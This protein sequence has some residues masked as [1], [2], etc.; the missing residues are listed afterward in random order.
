MKKII[1]LL[2]ICLL[3]LLV[4]GKSLTISPNLIDKTY[5]IGD[6]QLSPITVTISNND[7]TSFNTSLSVVD[8]SDF[9]YLS[10]QGL[11]FNGT[12]S[13][14]FIVYFNV[15]SSATVGLKTE[16][17]IYSDGTNEY[18]P[19]YLNIKK[20]E[21]G[22]KLIANE[23]YR[24]SINIKT[25]PYSEEFS[26]KVS[27][28][29]T[30]GITINSLR[31]DGTFTFPSGKQPLRLK[32]AVPSGEYEPGDTFK[33]TI[34]YDTSE[35]DLKTYYPSII[36]DAIDNNND[37]S[38]GKTIK[39][40]IT[41]VGNKPS[42]SGN[43]SQAIFPECSLSTTNVL[44]EN[45][46]NLIC[47]NYVDQNILIDI[48]I[49]PEYIRGNSRDYDDSLKKYS[50]SFNPL[51]EGKTKMTIQFKYEGAPIGDTKVFNLD[52]TKTIK[53]SVSGVQFKFIPSI[54]S[55]KDGSNVSVLV[56]ANNTEEIVTS[57][58]TILVNGNRIVDGNGNDINYFTVKAGTNYEINA[59]TPYGSLYTTIMIPKP[60]IGLSASKLNPEIDEVVTI[61]PTPSNARLFYSN[62]YSSNVEIY[63][64]AFTPNAEGLHV[65]TAYLDGYNNNNL[66]IDVSKKLVILTELPVKIKK[67]QLVALQL[68]KLANWCV[69]YSKDNTT[70]PI[71]YK[72]EN[73]NEY[74]REN[75]GEVSFMPKDNG[76]YYLRL[77]GSDVASWTIKGNKFL[78]ILKYV[79][80]VLLAGI[81]IFFVVI[82]LRKKGEKE[83]SPSKYSM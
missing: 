3:P 69:L 78:T 55:L 4:E 22:C 68:S 5:I 38:I 56:K 30:K 2:V 23:D 75:N 26:V 1:L 71:N 31:E 12:E 8:L 15:S 9:V 66:T 74:C 65:I 73:E 48:G 6:P 70:I 14:S 40:Q 43:Y 50:W 62:S 44:L 82:G 37:D 24:E 33:Y 41:V 21:T 76:V 16:K 39:Y 10:K 25:P 19:V 47:T 60:T 32:G 81:V 79:G 29:C 58:V 59:N 64:N 57:G 72:D 34:E 42:P 53:A 83:E 35:L 45:S 51:K 11:D 13:K 80:L 54:D 20:V 49:D 18:I 7:N 67:N 61:T 63:N 28:K 17:I 46:Y 77:R 27:S 52:I 36:I